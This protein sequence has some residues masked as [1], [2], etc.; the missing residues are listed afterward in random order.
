MRDGES[1]GGGSCGAGT[2]ACGVRYTT[3]TH[4]TPMLRLALA[5]ALLLALPACGDPA[6]PAAASGEPAV[7]APTSTVVVDYVGTLEDG[8][9]FDSGRNVEFSLL[10]VV[11]G[12]QEHIAGMTE[13]ETKTFDV[14]PEKGY[15]AAGGGPIP[16]N[17]TLTFEVTLHEVK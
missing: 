16:P 2:P 8:T 1:P 10:E 15:G 4:P 11:P 17:A 14:P 7:A 5:A 9:E 6:A 13:G 12:F 3:A